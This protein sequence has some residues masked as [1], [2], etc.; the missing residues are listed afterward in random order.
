M[1]LWPELVYS[2]RTWTK[3]TKLAEHKWRDRYYWLGH[4]TDNLSKCEYVHVESKKY[5]FDCFI[6]KVL[7]FFNN[8]SDN[9]R[10]T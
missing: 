8:L 7:H 4:D 5:N 1:I 6:L 3:Y 10:L 9:V 2:P